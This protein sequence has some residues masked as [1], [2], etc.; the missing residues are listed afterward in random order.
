MTG[1]G[2]ARVRWP[3]HT[4]S[5]RCRRAERGERSTGTPR[6]QADPPFARGLCPRGAGRSH[7]PAV[8]RAGIGFSGACTGSQ[9]SATHQLAL[10]LKSQRVAA[11]S[12][13][14]ENPR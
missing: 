6:A 9:G 5:R 12:P 8:G 2:F 1:R 14:R 3:D 10:A 13:I 4:R 7:G 11:E